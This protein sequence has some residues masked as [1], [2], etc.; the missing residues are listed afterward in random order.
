MPKTRAR[1]YGLCESLLKLRRLARISA[2]ISDMPTIEV[3]N[4][5]R[6]R[7]ALTGLTTMT[8]PRWLPIAVHAAVEEA[9]DAE[10]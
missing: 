3:D 8:P 10:T 5:G 9:T 2:E 4:N 7:P 1:R 6:V